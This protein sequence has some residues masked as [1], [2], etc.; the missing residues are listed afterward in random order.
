[1]A[2]PIITSVTPTL[3]DLAGGD[4]IEI[5]GKYFVEDFTGKV[6]SGPIIDLV[7][8][9]DLVFFDARFDFQDYVEGFGF[10]KAVVGLPDVDAPGTYHLQV[11]AN[12][13]PSNVLLDVLNFQQF[14]EEYKVHHVRRRWAPVWAT[15]PRT[16]TTAPSGGSP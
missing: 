14:A 4:V 10:T 3:V 9:G 8:E 6:Y 12:G 1:M 7:D 2:S 15:G 5:T 13:A 11:T 16:L